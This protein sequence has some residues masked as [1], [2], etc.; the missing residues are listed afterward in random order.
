MEL[1]WT[2]SRAK[3]GVATPAG[4]SSQPDSLDVVDES[5]RTE[6]ALLILSS[7]SIRDDFLQNYGIMNL[8]NHRLSDNTQVLLRKRVLRLASIFRAGCAV[9]HV[10]AR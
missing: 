1:S 9:K 2:R 4:G 5:E 3:Y 10:I 7:S 8:Q 6:A